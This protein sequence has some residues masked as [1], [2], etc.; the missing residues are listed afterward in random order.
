[1]NNEGDSPMFDDLEALLK[2]AKKEA[3]KA[4]ERRQKA[5]ALVPKLVIKRQ[6][7]QEWTQ[8]QTLC[9]IH[10]TSDGT[11][12]ALGLFTEYLRNGSRW[13]RPSAE[14]ISPHHTEIVTGSWWLNPTIREIPVDSH[15]EVR[16]IRARFEMLIQEFEEDNNL[17]SISTLMAE[18]PNPIEDPMDDEDEDLEDE[19]ENEDEDEDEG[20]ED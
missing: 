17:P 9:L 20:E 13:L 16:A 11:E 8:G 14:T 7:D 1:M 12:T 19:D 10:R 4:K 2:Q 6:A 5:R 15:H 3:F 18:T